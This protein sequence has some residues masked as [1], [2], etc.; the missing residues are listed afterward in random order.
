MIKGEL[1]G[2]ELQNASKPQH[3]ERC[4]QVVVGGHRLKPERNERAS[5]RAKEH[6]LTPLTMA[7]PKPDRIDKPVPRKLGADGDRKLK[8]DRML[9]L[10]TWGVPKQRRRTMVALCQDAHSSR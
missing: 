6:G 8:Y 2:S 3:A 1:R 9:L 7:P 5:L 10:P 4:R